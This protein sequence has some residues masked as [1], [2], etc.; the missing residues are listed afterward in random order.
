[1]RL[2][3]LELASRLSFFLWS[4]IPDE[5][6][7]RLAESGKLS[8]PANL[9]REVRRM[10]NDRRASNALVRGFISQWLNL[11]RLDEYT[12]D[13]EKQ[14]GLRVAG[15]ALIE[16]FSRE[17]ELFAESTIREDSSVAELLS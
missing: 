14:E 17:T 13:Y 9:R 1:Y 3:D 12:P 4:S 16:A 6:L 11:R 5:P 15:R 10:L 8:E 2:S 7:L